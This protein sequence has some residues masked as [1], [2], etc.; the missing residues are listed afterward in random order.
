[1]IRVEMV[2]ADDEALSEKIDDTL[3]FE[4][5]EEAEGFIDYTNSRFEAGFIPSWYVY[6]RIQV[7]RRET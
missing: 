3:D 2:L 1:M 7:K 5:Q 6:A 4:T